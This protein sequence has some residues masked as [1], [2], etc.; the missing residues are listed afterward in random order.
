MA[1]ML[2]IH[3]EAFDTIVQLEHDD[4]G[5]EELLKLPHSPASPPV[6]EAFC[7]LAKAPSPHTNSREK[8]SLLH[9]NIRGDFVE[10]PG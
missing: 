2:Y 5:N 3:N 6:S 1:F 7:D 4:D 9:T 10:D 8:D